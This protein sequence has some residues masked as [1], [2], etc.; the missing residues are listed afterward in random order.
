MQ[1]AQGKRR[2]EL[3]AIRSKIDNVLEYAR[4]VVA[5]LEALEAQGVTVAANIAHS[6]RMHGL[7][8]TFGNLSCVGSQLGPPYVWASLAKRLNYEAAADNAALRARRATPQ[9]GSAQRLP[10]PTLEAK[11]AVPHRRPGPA[12]VSSIPVETAPRTPDSHD[13]SD[14]HGTS[15]NIVPFAFSSHPSQA[16]VREA[17]SDY[18]VGKAAGRIFVDHAPTGTGKSWALATETVAQVRTW[19]APKTIIFLAPEKRHLAA[20]LRDLKAGLP[21]TPVLTLRAKGDGLIEHGIPSECPLRGQDEKKYVQAVERAIELVSEN[22]SAPNLAAFKALLEHERVGLRGR[23][24]KWVEAQGRRETPQVTACQGCL[25]MFPGNR[26]FE[27]RDRPLVALATYEKLYFGLDA[28]EIDHGKARFIRYSPFVSTSSGRDRP[29]ENCMIICEEYSHGHQ[30]IAQQIE[31]Q[32]LTVS[33]FEAAESVVRSFRDV[34]QKVTMEIESHDAVLH[35]K[36]AKRLLEIGNEVGRRR[37]DFWLIEESVRPFRNGRACLLLKS[38]DARDMPSFVASLSPA[39]SSL[40]PSDKLGVALDEIATEAFGEDCYRARVRRFPSSASLKEAGYGSLPLAAEFARARTLEPIAWCAERLTDITAPLPRESKELLVGYFLEEVSQREHSVVEYL[41]SLMWRHHS[42]AGK[43]GSDKSRARDLLDEFYLRGYEFLETRLDGFEVRVMARLSRHS[44]EAMLH[45][46]ATA[47]NVIYISSASATIR[48]AIT[49]S[50]FD[51]LRRIGHHVQLLDQASGQRVMAEKALGKATPE[52]IWGDSHTPSIVDVTFTAKAD[53]TAMLDTLN[54]F[55]N[56][57]VSEAVA[58]PVSRYAILFFNSNQNCEQAKAGFERLSSREGL[59]IHCH[60]VTAETFANGGMTIIREEIARHLQAEEAPRYYVIFATYRGLAT[61]ANLHGEMGN[62]ESLSENLLAYV[63]GGPLRQ[64]VGSDKLGVD[65]SDI[66]LVEPL[67]HY[68][69]ENNFYRIGHQLAAL[70]D[71]AWRRIGRQIFQTASLSQQRVLEPW[72]VTAGAVRRTRHYVAV[73]F[74][75]AMQSIGRM[76]RTLNAAAAPRVFLNRHFAPIFAAVDAAMIGETF[77]SP[78]IQLVIE[79]AKSRMA[80]ADMLER[81]DYIEAVDLSSSEFFTYLATLVRQ[82]DAARQVWLQVR[83]FLARHQV[84]PRKHS[85]DMDSD[86]EAIDTLLAQYGVS[87][88]DFYFDIPEEFFRSGNGSYQLGFDR[89][90]Y[91]FQIW[92][93]DEAPLSSALAYSGPRQSPRGGA[94][95][96]R[97]D[98]MREVVVAVEYE[99]ECRLLIDQYCKK[100]VLPDEDVPAHL[101]ERCDLFIPQCEACVDAKAWSLTT[102]E[103]VS[104]Q[105]SLEKLIDDARMKLRLMQ[106]EAPPSGWAPRRYLYAFRHWWPA[107]AERQGRVAVFFQGDAT[108]PA[109]T[110]DW[111]VAFVHVAEHWVINTV[112]NSLDGTSAP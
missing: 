93:R 5:F 101:F 112:L 94:L 88:R 14:D 83:S 66:V 75:S 107:L 15:L 60:I 100:S 56:T 84:L 29:I 45:H 95:F 64:H 25:S 99:N 59:D 1:R 13:A 69:N 31:E 71:L 39:Y 52:V 91:R 27:R 32:A 68:V 90:E 49:N 6:G 63:G 61:G 86:A 87:L 41:H 50:D 58:A 40:F 73:Q 80:V 20:L 8:F 78:T 22:Q 38:E 79:S 33:I 98:L 89:D 4:N 7:R 47:G 19:Q 21:D 111:D 74:D 67:T 54:T 37:G 18:A 10:E 72:K 44:P 77:L 34:F 28:F 11:I 23:C 53:A 96:V 85:G 51:W 3:E 42:Q 103:N 9:M 108:V 35:A 12:T 26:L 62:L 102:M 48:S 17:M 105:A 110:G 97:P 82:D 65:V 106:A 24:R 109:A 30:R 55:A 70:G 104:N 92:S 46:L 76:D 16:F 81:V 43:L 57:L 2:A 36:H